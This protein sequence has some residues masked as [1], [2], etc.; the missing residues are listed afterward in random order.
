MSPLWT[1]AIALAAAAV[2]VVGMLL[3]TSA[4]VV[5][6]IAGPDF[7]PPQRGDQES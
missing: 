7:D 4:A 5:S 6:R 2:V 3:M 1:A